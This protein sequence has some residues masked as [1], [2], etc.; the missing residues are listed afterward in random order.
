MLLPPS[1]S[2]EIKF[3][4]AGFE[5]GNVF[6]NK[7]PIRSA[8][9]CCAGCVVKVPLVETVES[10]NP[11]RSS[12]EAFGITLLTITYCSDAPPSV[13]FFPSTSSSSS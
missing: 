13:D 11:N 3:C 2:S 8:V 1:R 6:P 10:P 7:S 4:T 9:V 5:T 12:R